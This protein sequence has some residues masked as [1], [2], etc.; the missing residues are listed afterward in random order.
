METNE[1]FYMVIPSNSN[2][3]YFTEN[4][5]FRF[6]THLKREIKLHDLWLVGLIDIHIPW[7]IVHLQDNEASYTFHTDEEDGRLID[8]KCVVY[9]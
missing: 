7:N 5:T 6:T 4:I 1:D 3:S 9:P 8:K 2:M